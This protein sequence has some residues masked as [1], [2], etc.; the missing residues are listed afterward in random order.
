[1]R[2]VA[3]I[4][5]AE[6]RDDTG[7][8]LELDERDDVGALEPRPLGMARHDEAVHGAPSGRFDRVPRERVAARAHRPRRVAERR[9]RGAALDEEL[10]VL[11]RVPEE[12]GIGSGRRSQPVAHLRRAS[13]SGLNFRIR[14]I[15]RPTTSPSSS[16]YVVT[17]VTKWPGP[18]RVRFRSDTDSMTVVDVITSPRRR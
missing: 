11:Q 14:N 5:A 18:S 12:A 3:R 7:P 17:Q 16:Q 6:V 13:R 10:S 2:D 8:L 1:D 9:A 4:H 15:C